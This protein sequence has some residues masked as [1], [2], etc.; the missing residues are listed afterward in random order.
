M[1]PAIASAK[2]SGICFVIHQFHHD[3]KNRSYAL[4]AAAE[5]GRDPRQIYK[6]LIVQLDGGEL[7]VAMLPAALTLSLKAL[8]KV[9][10]ARKATMAPSALAEK[11]T[12][13]LVGGISPLGQK[14]RLRAFLHEAALEQDSILV[15]GGRRGLEIELAPAD[16][17]HLTEAIAAPLA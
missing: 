1:T 16:L 15:S 7:V 11:T 6:T 2:Q 17:L 13:Y 12:G 5:L 4:E 10:H 3:P 9:A 14:K 8:T